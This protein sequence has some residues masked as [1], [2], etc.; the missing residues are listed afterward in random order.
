MSLLTLDFYLL[1]YTYVDAT[2]EGRDIGTV[3][4]L[5]FFL[6]TEAN[7]KEMIRLLL[8]LPE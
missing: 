3:N 8:R 1:K 7:K 4:L 2:T 5:G 6:Q